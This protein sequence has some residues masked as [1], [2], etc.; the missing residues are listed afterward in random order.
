[1]RSIKLST[2]IASFMCLLFAAFLFGQQ[3]QPTSQPSDQSTAQPAAQQPDSSQQPA[4]A[5]PS[6]QTDQ[7]Q[8]PSSSDQSAT[9]SDQSMD[10]TSGAGKMPKTASDVPLLALLGT[11]CLAGAGAVHLAL[12]SKHSA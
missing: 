8:S 5:Q 2:L 9:P 10:Q 1:M 12:K 4:A 3:Q 11:L 7:S 6:Q